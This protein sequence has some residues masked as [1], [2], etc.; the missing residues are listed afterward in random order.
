MRSTSSSR[1]ARNRQLVEEKIASTLGKIE[2][3]NTELHGLYE[4]LNASSLVSLIPLEILTKI[5]L[6]ATE[7]EFSKKLPMPLVIGRV[8]RAWRKAAWDTPPVWKDLRINFRPSLCGATSSQQVMIKEWVQRSGNQP[9]NLVLRCHYPRQP[10]GEFCVLDVFQPLLDVSHR[11]RRFQVEGWGGGFYR[12][13]KKL[14]ETQHHFTLLSKIT[15]FAA[16]PEGLPKYGWDFRSAPLLNVTINFAPFDYQL[17]W[18]EVISFVGCFNLE[19]SLF[20]LK[21]ASK[22]LQTCSFNLES[23]GR[24]EPLALEGVNLLP[25]L[26]TLLIGLQNDDN[27][28]VDLI[29]FFQRLEVPALTS[30]HLA[31]DSADFGYLLPSFKDLA[32]RSKFS[33]KILT[34]ELPTGVSEKALVKL[35][36]TLPT[37]TMF[38]LKSDKNQRL[39]SNLT[40]AMLDPTSGRPITPESKTTR[41]YRMY[42]L[43]PRQADHHGQKSAQICGSQAHLQYRYQILQQALGTGRPQRNEG[44]L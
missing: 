37:L 10:K 40:I 31:L 14:Q 7:S 39:L 33:L 26:K 4:L 32:H 28:W 23:Q 11:W 41:L 27:T 5:F 42:L 30:L 29:P 3:L 34:L 13:Q 44:I 25:N 17:A 20:V 2:N 35:L 1:L 36:A 6:F 16:P 19:A 24:T 12:L 21:E 38:T 43:Q 18:N 8:C 22:S 15:M 9:L